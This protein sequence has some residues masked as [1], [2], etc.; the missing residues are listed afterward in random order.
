MGHEPFQIHSAS[1]QELQVSAS[2]RLF[3]Q[4]QTTDARQ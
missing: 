3:R 4:I 2:E 1:R